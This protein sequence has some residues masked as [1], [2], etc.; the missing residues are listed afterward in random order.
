MKPPRLAVPALVLALAACATPE[1]P[2]SA[3]PTP[4]ALPGSAA[5][6]ARID[7]LAQG[8]DGRVGIAVE[9]VGSGRVD[10]HDGMALY[11]QQSVAK[12]W[13]ALAVLDA[14][15][16][17]R[18]V[19]A[20]EVLVTRSDMSVFNQPIQKLLTDQGYRTS[21][22]G[23]LQLAL[24]ESDNAANDILLKRVGGG[25]A[26]RRV[27][28]DHGLG[29]IRAGLSERELESRIAAVRWKPEYS[30]GQ[31]FWQVRDAVRMDQRVKAMDAYLADPED[32]ASPVAIVEAL[33]R[34]QRGGLLFPATTD[35]MLQMLKATRTGPQ[36]LAAGLPPGWTIAH[37]TG[38]GQDLGDLSTGYNDV[39]LITA[40]DGH[41]YAVAVMIAS[42]RR[43]VPERQALMAAVAAAVAAEHDA[44]RPPPPP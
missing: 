40:P 17:G 28:V 26:V 36:R 35:H 42:T 43:P 9:D 4:S 13:T 19:L 38:T 33:S 7:A 44:S 27:L 1:P 22:D 5:L 10:A 2:A 14:V 41:T 25:E 12:L 32:G 39:G 30:F 34:L 20:D 16:A 21:I 29:G 8:F 24:A 18:M 6:Q 31:A 3:P 11:P 15:D 37:K 23:L